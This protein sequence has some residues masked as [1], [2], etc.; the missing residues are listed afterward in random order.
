[1]SKKIVTDH[2][3]KEREDIDISKDYK[4]EQWIWDKLH[5]FYFPDLEERQSSQDEH[6]KERI[7]PSVNY[8][9]HKP[10]YVYMNNG[11]MRDLENITHT[12][13]VV[14]HLN[15]TSVTFYLNEPMCIYNVLKI[16]MGHTLTF[17]SEFNGKENPDY[18]RSDELDC[19]H[20]Y[21]IRNN[22]TNVKVKTCDYKSE[23]VFP[24]YDK[25]MTVTCEDTFIK[26][27]VLVNVIDDSY[28]NA[29]ILGRA[30]SDFSKKFINLNWRWT[31]HRNL[32]AAFLAKS[33]A[34]VSFVYETDMVKLQTTPWFDLRKC[35]KKYKN[36]LYEGLS[37]IDNN[38]PLNV[39]VSFE[40]LLDIQKTPYP[41][42]ITID[43]V[44]DPSVEEDHTIEKHYKDIFC[45]VVTESRFAQPTPNYSEKVHQPMWYRKPFILMAPPGTLKYLHDN[46]YKTFS[47]F[48][49]ESY[50]DCT[51][52]EERLY[53]IFEVIKYIE[54]KSIDELKDIYK[55]MEPI[56]SYNRS[57][58]EDFI[59]KWI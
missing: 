19:I 34:Y 7:L 39:D 22:L 25:W 53:K 21:I 32:I 9:D 11:R 36:R 13:E 48:W 5:W 35:P 18:L 41:V 55:A 58:V 40:K 46:G 8:N 20:D 2:L 52:H 59:Y 29:D 12:P 28:D 47:D 27:A 4:E 14:E 42:N 51:N 45:D 15:E 43:E 44:F 37:E 33:D 57:H 54:S 49:D 24:Y 16:G 26:N 50:D 10:I 6:L 3:Q 31:P 23:K 56:L 1:M 30:A 17:Y 38:G